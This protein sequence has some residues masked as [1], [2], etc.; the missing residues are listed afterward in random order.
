MNALLLILET[1]RFDARNPL[2]KEASIFA[3]RNLLEGNLENQRCIGELR[4]QGVAENPGLADL[5]MEAV[6]EGGKL[7]IVQ[8][9]RSRDSPPPEL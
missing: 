5:G 1:S 7:K 9:D 8:Q 6:Q 4:M 3:L 2:I